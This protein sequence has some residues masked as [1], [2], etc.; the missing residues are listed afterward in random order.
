LYFAKEEMQGFVLPRPPQH[1]EGR[2]YEQFFSRPVLAVDVDRALAD[3]QPTRI[4]GLVDD[5]ASRWFPA[6]AFNRTSQDEFALRTRIIQSQHENVTV[7]RVAYAQGRALILERAAHNLLFDEQW[8][9]ESIERHSHE[10]MWSLAMS[11]TQRSLLE[12]IEQEERVGRAAVQQLTIANFCTVVATAEFMSRRHLVASLLAQMWEVRHYEVSCRHQTAMIAAAQRDQNVIVEFEQ[13]CRRY[14]L[15]MHSTVAAQTEIVTEESLLRSHLLIG[16]RES[17]RFIVE[18]FAEEGC[19]VL[20]RSEGLINCDFSLVGLL[21]AQAV[22]IQAAFRG[23]SARN[24]LQGA[25]R[26]HRL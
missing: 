25:A 8:E 15:A 16:F 26:E 3:D 9:R 5:D 18:C 2:R 24:R 21:S 7:L 22:V 12:N 6:T 20:W 19:H 23:W 4:G 14:L 1:R 11:T 10:L 17:L 13:V